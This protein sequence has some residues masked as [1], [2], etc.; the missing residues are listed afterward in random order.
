MHLRDCW[1]RRACCSTPWRTGT[2]IEP[3]LGMSHTFAT[4]R[5]YTHRQSRQSIAAASGSDSP[6]P[7]RLHR[8]PRP[9]LRPAP[10]RRHA[11]RGRGEQGSCAHG[12]AACSVDTDITDTPAGREGGGRGACLRSPFAARSRRPS[13]AGAYV[14]SRALADGL[15]LRCRTGSRFFFFFVRYI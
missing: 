14:A 5:A 7:P 11:G 4:G 10:R 13:R 8:R 15:E 12:E 2:G 3:E 9:A 6:P 1:Q